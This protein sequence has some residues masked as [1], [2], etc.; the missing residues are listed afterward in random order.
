MM[1]EL[2]DRTHHGVVGMV[3]VVGGD[4]ANANTYC[5]ARH[6]YRDE[7]G[8]G[9]CYEMTVR[10]DDRFRRKDGVWRLAHRV[11]VL[12]GD[13]AWPTGRGPR[14]GT[15]NINTEGAP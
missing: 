3:P 8:T 11:L 12:I 13:A 7:A 9:H 14:R 6:Y 2:Y 4:A 15:V 10:Y 1:K 5:Y